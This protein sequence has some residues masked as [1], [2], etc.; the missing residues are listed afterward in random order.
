[1]RL[2]IFAVKNRIFCMVL[3]SVVVVVV[4][5]VIKHVCCHVISLGNQ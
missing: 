5:L 3:M 4:V 2:S 1:M